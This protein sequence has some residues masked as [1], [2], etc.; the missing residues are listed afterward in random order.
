MALLVIGPASAAQLPERPALPA[1]PR[2]QPPPDGWNAMDAELFFD[3][4]MKLLEGDRPDFFARRQAAAPV[5]VP[6]PSPER[7]FIW[8]RLIS[9]DV[10][11]D[12][13]KDNKD[14]ILEVTANAS[15]FKGG[16]YEEARNAFSMIAVSFAVIAD[17]D[18]EA[19]WQREAAD[20]RDLFARAGFNCKGGTDA[21]FN[22]SRA[23]G[24]DLES[25]VRGDRVE[26]RTEPQKGRD[27]FWSGV[28]GR[29]PLMK[30][31]EAAHGV[32]AAGTA[33]AAEFRQLADRLIHESEIVAMIGEVIQKEDYDSWD[34]PAYREFA[35]SMRDAAIAARDAAAD[36]D[37]QAAAVAV[38][39]IK[40]ACEACHQDYR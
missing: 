24:E 9:A 2:R 30:R 29:P 10:L 4:A 7:G 21:S 22:E 28:A 8:S 23:R 38:G 19:R 26:T 18:A 31:L 15:R 12:E 39:R 6:E 5:G 36:K 40:R 3:N 16:G 14:A 34:D 33:S 35:A 37:G 17:F 20:L 27:F 13:I 25:L 32:L 1:R 11:A